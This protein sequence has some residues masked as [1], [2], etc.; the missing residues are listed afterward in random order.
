[1][2]LQADSED[3]KT[4]M[5]ALDQE[6][7]LLRK[8][9][10]QITLDNNNGPTSKEINEARDQL[11]LNYQKKQAVL[12]RKWRADDDKLQKKVDTLSGTSRSESAKDM[13]DIQLMKD[14]LAA[15]KRREFEIERPKIIEGI[16]K[17]IERIDDREEEL[18]DLRKEQ[19][20]LKSRF[21]KAKEAEALKRLDEKNMDAA[22]VKEL[23]AKRGVTK[24]YPPLDEEHMSEILRNMYK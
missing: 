8:H 9:L 5:S 15:L 21:D 11:T 12:E 22:K 1:M 16:T 14:Y 4:T 7:K 17:L 13:N 10:M 6:R 19:R 20:A 2:S 3:F 24:S 18:E 23:M